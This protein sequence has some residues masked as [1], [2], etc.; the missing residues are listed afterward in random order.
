MAKYTK[1]G[2]KSGSNTGITDA[3]REL[4]G[5]D[6][7]RMSGEDLYKYARAAQKAVNDNARRIYK[8][9]ED[10]NPAWR[11]L[12]K[13]GGYITLKGMRKKNPDGTYS[14]DVNKLRHELA[15][16]RKFLN[17]KTSNVTE[18]RKYEQNIEKHMPGYSKMTAEQ[19]REFW[20]GIDE[21]RAL[22]AYDIV[23]HEI[24]SDETLSQMHEIYVKGKEE[25]NLTPEQILD[26]MQKRLV[27]AYE[28]TVR[29]TEDINWI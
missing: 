19:K 25:L 14:Y 13:S 7:S 3:I 21:L 23:A 4:K 22:G 28:K 15:R 20:K 26:D 10:A 2:V 6:I 16:A 11:A 8:K 24:G 27:K 29:G 17:M 5:T 12:D 9:Y 1:S 18:A